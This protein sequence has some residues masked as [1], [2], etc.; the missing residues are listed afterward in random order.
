MLPILAQ[1]VITAAVEAVVGFILKK[2]LEYAKEKSAELMEQSPALARSTGKAVMEHNLSYPASDQLGAK[3]VLEAIRDKKIEPSLTD[4]YD[5]MHQYHELHKH[6][7][8][9]ENKSQAAPN[10]SDPEEGPNLPRQKH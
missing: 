3:A 5:K 9:P 6:D 2:A 10:S 7:T 8:I 1:V 4:I